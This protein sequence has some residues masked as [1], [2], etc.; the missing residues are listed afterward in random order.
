MARPTSAAIRNRR[1]HFVPAGLVR[2][3][4]TW[5]GNFRLIDDPEAERNLSDESSLPLAGI[6]RQDMMS[7]VLGFNSRPW[8][9]THHFLA[10]SFLV[11]SR[12]FFFASSGFWMYKMIALA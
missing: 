11:S 7:H 9:S 10:F 6:D 8:R 12:I 4:P 5:N 2:V 1:R 3:V